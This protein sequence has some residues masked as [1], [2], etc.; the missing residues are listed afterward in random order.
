MYS[1]WSIQSN[2]F[3]PS[4]FVSQ[5]RGPQVEVTRWRSR[6][7]SSSV[8]AYG[9]WSP[10]L[11]SLRSSKRIIIKIMKRNP[12]DGT[13]KLT[14]MTNFPQKKWRHFLWCSSDV[15]KAEFV[16][17]RELKSPVGTSCFRGR[18]RKQRRFA[19]RW[20]WI[21]GGGGGGKLK[22]G[23]ISTTALAV[24]LVWGALFFY[25]YIRVCIYPTNIAGV[26]L[27]IGL[28]HYSNACSGVL[29]LYKWYISDMKTLR[30]TQMST[31]P[32]AK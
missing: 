19:D 5:E 10:M 14:S 4:I 8:A 12:P 9:L 21:R 25:I 15:L 26:N 23:M 32:I 17:A 20:E 2:L 11:S 29:T 6:I 18:I 24:S 16:T 7:S 1:T 3:P 27:V 13:F 31:P 22:A 28:L 30:A